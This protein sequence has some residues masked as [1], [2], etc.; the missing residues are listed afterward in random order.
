VENTGAHTTSSETPLQGGKK[1][2]RVDYTEVEAKQ[3]DKLAT[4]RCPEGLVIGPLG[5]RPIHVEIRI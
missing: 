5:N 4:Y 3:L 2:Q 1:Y